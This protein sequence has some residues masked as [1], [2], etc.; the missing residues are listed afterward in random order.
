M[1]RNQ[2]KELS[3]AFARVPPGHF[4][5]VR[6]VAVVREMRDGE[7]DGFAKFW[8]HDSFLSGFASIQGFV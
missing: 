4:P 3:A 2:A 5:K 8:P 7:I 6:L 1:C